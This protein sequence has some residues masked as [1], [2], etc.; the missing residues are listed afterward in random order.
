MSQGTS[1]RA[2]LGT[3]IS[4]LGY[5]GLL[6]FGLGCGLAFL[7][8]TALASE[9]FLNYSA[10]ILTF[11]GG[12]HW[13]RIIANEESLTAPRAVFALVASN[14]LALLAWAALLLSE[15]GALLPTVLLTAGFVAV[16]AVELICLPAVARSLHRRYAAFRAFLTV[17][18][19]LLH[20]VFY[21]LLP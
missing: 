16:Y 2:A 15:L 19:L 11:L 6:P 9:V 18:V 8:F 13:G 7:G 10:V 5:A 12:S 17:V 1:E 4:T 14:V 3:A 20:G 21:L